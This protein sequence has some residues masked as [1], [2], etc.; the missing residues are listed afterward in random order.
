M[1]NLLFDV[2]SVPYPTPKGGSGIGLIVGIVAVVVVIAVVLC[3][4][5]IRRKKKNAK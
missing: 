1:T 3:V 5:L 4:I 2:P